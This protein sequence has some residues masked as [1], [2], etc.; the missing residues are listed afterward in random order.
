MRTIQLLAIPAL[1]G[2]AISSAFATATTHIWGPSTDIQP[3]K[4]WHV[5]A[6]CYQPLAAEQDGGGT[7]YQIPPVTNLGLTVGILPYQKVQMEVGFDHKAGY[8]LADRYPLYF[9]TKIGVIE[10]GLM[11]GFPALAAGIF[12]IGTKSDVTNYD[13]FYLRGAKTLGNLGRVSL[14]WFSGNDKL[15]LDSKGKKSNSGVHFAWERTMSELSDKLWIC[16]EYMGSNSGYGT[17]NFGFS[18]KVADNASVLLGY[19]I[20]NDAN[21]IGAENYFSVQVDI[22]LP[23]NSGK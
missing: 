19:D 16:A 6:D 11:E 17:T 1:L 22:D 12:D 9:N 4:V 18:W 13:V 5:T 8:G 14:G 3:Y 2:I 7:G 15:L 10:N 23:F 21:L 20:L